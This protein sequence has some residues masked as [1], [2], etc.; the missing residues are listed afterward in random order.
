MAKSDKTN[1]KERNTELGE[2]TE[3]TLV[4]WFSLL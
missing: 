4:L 1:S 3:K 2:W